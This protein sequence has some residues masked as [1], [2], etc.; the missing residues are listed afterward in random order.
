ME[1]GSEWEDSSQYNPDDDDEDGEKD[2]RKHKRSAKKSKKSK[3]K[4]KKKSKKRE[5]VTCAHSEDL[6]AEEYRVRENQRSVKMSVPYRQRLAKLKW[7][8]IVGK[9]GG[10]LFT[11]IR[12]DAGVS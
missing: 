3:R 8:D 2:H 4:K 11:H 7:K 12:G 5:R 10:K 9:D 1:S 6:T